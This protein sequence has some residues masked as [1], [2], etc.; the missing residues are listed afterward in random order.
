MFATKYWYICVVDHVYV[1][2]KLPMGGHSLCRRELRSDC[3]GTVAITRQPGWT[4]GIFHSLNPPE[5]HLAVIILI[6]N[7]L[8]DILNQEM[9]LII[10]PKGTPTNMHRYPK[11]LSKD[12]KKD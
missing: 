4:N 10:S 6:V 5:G 11:A 7:I 8:D 1:Y 12:F 2:G 9:L 3:P